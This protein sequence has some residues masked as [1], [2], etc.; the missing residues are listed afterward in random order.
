[1]FNGRLFYQQNMILCA[2]LVVH[3]ITLKACFVILIVII[4]PENLFMLRFHAHN[5]LGLKVL[6]TSWR[7]P[8]ECHLEAHFKL[9]RDVVSH[10]L[11]FA[12]PELTS[13]CVVSH[14]NHIQIW[15]FC[16]SYCIINPGSTSGTI[17]EKH[18]RQN[19]KQTSAITETCCKNTV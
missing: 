12:C 3:Y 1:M 17:R 13:T 5:V 6:V 11:V 8:I 18:W 9:V 2:F 19:D 14:S 16:N 7:N 10:S 15:I 4:Y